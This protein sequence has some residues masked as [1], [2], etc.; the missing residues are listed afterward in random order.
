MGLKIDTEKCLI[1]D[2]DLFN[3]VIKTAVYVRVIGTRNT[4]FIE[5]GPLYCENGQEIHDATQKLRRK[6]YQRLNVAV[7]E[8]RLMGGI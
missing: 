3:M 7:E 8:N 6:I 1:W 4:I 2:N 5:E